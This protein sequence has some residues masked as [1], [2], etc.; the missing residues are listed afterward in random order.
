M[1]ETSSNINYIPLGTSS[2][3]GT[4]A[5]FDCFFQ[6]KNRREAIFHR[7]FVGILVFQTS[8]TNVQTWA[9]LEE[10]VCFMIISNKIFK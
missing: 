6:R 8:A 9:G 4:K 3:D 1:I 10:K 2:F 7:C 5:I